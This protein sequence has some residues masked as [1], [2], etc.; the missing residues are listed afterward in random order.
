MQ[1]GM[2]GAAAGNGK[3]KTHQ[4]AAVESP[5][6][7]SADLLA[8]H[9]HAQRHQVHVIKIPDLFLQG[10]AGLEFFHAR[11]FAD[12]NLISP[13]HGGAHSF[14]SSSVLIVSLR[15]RSVLS[16]DLSTRFIAIAMNVCLKARDF[17]SESLDAD[18]G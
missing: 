5:N 8:D 6:G 11:T 16:Y 12:G 13:G 17:A 7:L 4:L 10:D 1:I 2:P 18:T 3:R 9:E 14:G 15:L